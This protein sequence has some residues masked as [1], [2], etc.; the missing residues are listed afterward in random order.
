MSTPA[1]AR[2]P[3]RAGS[4]LWLTL[5]A[6]TAMLIALAVRHEMW[7]DE[8]RAFSV[9]T[10]AASWGQ[11]LSDLHQEGHPALWY[12]VL[13]AAYAVTHS[14]LVLPVAALLIAV[15]T[16]YLILRYA[17]F[18]FWLRV[19]A[20]FGVFLGF[21]LSVVARNYGI[22]VLLMIATCVVFPRRLER[23]WLPATS[24]AMMANTSVHGALASL[25]ILFILLA[26]A[27]NAERRESLS[28]L[29][30]ILSV[31][32][33]VVAVAIAFWTARPTPDMVWAFNPGQLDLARMGRTILTDPGLAL[34]GVLGSNVAAA[35]EFPWRFLHLNSE[36]ASRVIVDA[37]LLWLAWSLRR[38]PI[39]LIAMIITIVGFELLFRH[40]YSGSLRHEGVIAFLLFSICWLAA[41]ARLE[42]TDPAGR[43]RI[44]LGLLPLFVV[45]S[46]ALPFVARRYF[47]KP[48]SGSKAYGKFLASHPK[49]RD[50]ILM[51]EPDYL[52]EAM[53]YYAP[54][55]VYMPRQ[56]E[57]HY[58]VYFDRGQKRIQD[59]T[60]TGLL[61]IADRVAC[62][63]RSTV[64]LAL[65]N[66]DIARKRAGRA[67][68]GYK[69]AS[70]T[71]TDLERTL[72]RRRTTL[73]ASFPVAISDES[74]HIFEVSPSC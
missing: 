21:E 34:K 6:Y 61:T 73:V 37:V 33:V 27:F 24:L 7:R 63:N 45:Q 53:P 32:L 17:P 30:T 52:M 2:R 38:R 20:I 68:L 44:A 29:Q 58:R 49:Y 10:R 40:V 60:L 1:A 65:G 41:D 59:L 11:M 42:R 54:N 39:H 18:P 4:T 14:N 70:F 51:G 74:Y 23:P 35:G 9:A 64:L 22:G 57:F 25:V 36:A 46:A 72:L 19:L 16:A 8:V 31:A 12:V 56:G 26:D 66:T 15:A 3:D 13:R 50:A 47:F 28:R 71:W 48:A 62:A 5:A 67:T 43:R 69:G 55:R